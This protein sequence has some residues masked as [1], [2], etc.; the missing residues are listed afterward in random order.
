MGPIKNIYNSDCCDK[1]RPKAVVFYGMLYLF[2]FLC[3][4]AFGKLLS[5]LADICVTSLDSKLRK[6]A[7]GKDF[8]FILTTQTSYPI[9]WYYIETGIDESVIEETHYLAYEKSC[10]NKGETLNEISVLCAPDKKYWS[11]CG[12]EINKCECPTR[13]EM[14][15]VAVLCDVL[16]TSNEESTSRSWKIPVL[17]CNVQDEACVDSFSKLAHQMAHSLCFVPTSFGMIVDERTV[18]LYQFQRDRE[19]GYIDVYQ[20]NFHLTKANESIGSVLVRILEEM[21]KCIVCTLVEDV[22]NVIPHN[23]SESKQVTNDTQTRKVQACD[24]CWQITGI[25]ERE[26]VMS[27]I[28]DHSFQKQ[29]HLQ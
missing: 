1:I 9:Y 7:H 26:D 14:C 24:N 20:Q 29:T 8:D 18:N 22:A 10:A 15:D 17:L 13:S 25:K 6:S 2:L 28:S 3:R 12:Y 11:K 16:E 23:Q 5:M 19:N 27:D 21:T 4:N